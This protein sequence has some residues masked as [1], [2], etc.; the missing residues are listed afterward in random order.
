MTSTYLSIAIWMLAVGPMPEAAAC[1][2]SVPGANGLPEWMAESPEGFIWVGSPK[3][4][5]HVPEDGHWTAMG[6]D[7]N[8]FD[9]CWWWREG[10]RA[11]DDPE[12]ELVITATRLDASSAPVSVAD[13]TSAMF[14]GRDLM[15]AGMAFPSSGCWEVIG[16]FRDEKLRF[17]FNVGY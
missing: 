12:P 6:P 17:V 4:A 13:A 5:A 1:E 9:K 8:Y 14:T 2:V 16:Q 15:L 10:Y 7:H 11:L 3:L